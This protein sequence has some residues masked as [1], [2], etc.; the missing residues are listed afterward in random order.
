M[1]RIADTGFDQGLPQAHGAHREAAGGNNGRGWFFIIT[2]ILCW[3]GFWL[4][5]GEHGDDNRYILLTYAMLYVTYV[6][7][8]LLDGGDG[9]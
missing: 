2:A 6:V 7:L 8:R 3:K 5:M 9:L 4:V 1:D